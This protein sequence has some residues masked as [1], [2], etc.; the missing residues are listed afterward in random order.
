MGDLA[1]DLSL[2]IAG[3]PCDG[4]TFD[5]KIR[6]VFVCGSTEISVHLDLVTY[7]KKYEYLLEFA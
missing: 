1:R 6:P 5:K 7:V 3:P 2:A 4:K